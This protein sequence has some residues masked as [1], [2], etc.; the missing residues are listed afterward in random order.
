LPAVAGNT[1]TV[2]QLWSGEVDGRDPR[3]NPDDEIL[4]MPDILDRD[5]GIRNRYAAPVPDLQ[6][7]NCIR[8][9]S[10][11]YRIYPELFPGS[12][13]PRNNSSVIGL[14][15]LE[16]YDNTAIAQYGAR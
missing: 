8:I 16:P 12:E 2:N 7:R 13:S 5:H 11:R 14:F 9:L 6:P 15:P 1:I 3:L 10:I 4:E